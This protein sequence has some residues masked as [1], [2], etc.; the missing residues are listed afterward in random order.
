MAFVCGEQARNFREV[1]ARV[2]RLARGLA[3]RGVTQGDRVA[4]LMGNS[5][6]MLEAVFVGWRLGGDRRPG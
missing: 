2:N 1:D 6:E 5:I 3:A 4:V